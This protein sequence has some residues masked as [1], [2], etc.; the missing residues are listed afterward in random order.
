LRLM[1]LGERG[2]ASGRQ[3]DIKI[4]PAA[5]AAAAGDESPS[6]VLRWWHSEVGALVQK[7]WIYLI[8]EP[9]YKALAVNMVYSLVP[10]VFAF[11]LR[12]HAPGADIS[13][14]TA[15]GRL[16]PI[17]SLGIMIVIPSA[18]LL[19]TLALT[20]NV[21]GGEASAITVLLTMP[22]RRLQFLQAKNIAYLPISLLIASVGAIAGAVIMHGFSLLPIVAAWIVMVIL[23]MMGTG[24]LVSVRFPHRIV[25]R[26]QRWRSGGNVAFGGGASGCGYALLYMLCYFAMFAALIPV[27]A[28]VLLPIAFD[29]DEIEPVTLLMAGVYSAGFYVLATRWAARI[30]DRRE[31]EMVAALAPEEA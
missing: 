2:P 28:A 20:F 24:N 5:V 22:T 18:L 23:V 11:G 25:I 21:F 29:H 8:R 15:S 7:E 31:P 12:Q 26:G 4:A 6:R 17:W 13:A 1:A 16:P 19:T 27:A 14:L 3:A 9:Q 10:M 30:L